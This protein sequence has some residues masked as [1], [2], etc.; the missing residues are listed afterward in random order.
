MTEELMLE[1]LKDLQARMGRLEGGQTAIRVELAS[2]GQQVG[3]LTTAVYAG[4]DRFVEIERRI[5]R[6]ERR[7]GL[8]ESES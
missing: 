7:L 4:Q 8:I 5:E 2:L 1:I 6:I 3:G